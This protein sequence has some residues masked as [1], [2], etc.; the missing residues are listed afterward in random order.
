MDYIRTTPEGA[1]K[2]ASM[3]NRYMPNTAGRLM[4][5]AE[6]V[7]KSEREGAHMYVAMAEGLRARIGKE[8]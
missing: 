6:A 1:R 8:S 4:D 7:E 2:L 3:I 5:A